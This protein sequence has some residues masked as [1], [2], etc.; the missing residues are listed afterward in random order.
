M[1]ELF[2]KHR[3]IGLLD[4]PE[5]NK[6]RKCHDWRNYIPEVLIATWKDMSSEGRIAAYLVAEC[7]AANEDWE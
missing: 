7:Q 6:A 5:F 2:R 4:N 3:E 1:N